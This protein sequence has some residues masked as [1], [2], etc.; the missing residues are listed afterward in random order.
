MISLMRKVDKT[1]SSLK[2][3]EKKKKRRKSVEVLTN[4]FTFQ[5]LN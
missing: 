5:I 4:I 2:I 3:K 1:L